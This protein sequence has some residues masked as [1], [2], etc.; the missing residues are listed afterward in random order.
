MKKSER[1]QILKV[2]KS[3]DWDELADIIIQSEIELDILFEELSIKE[4]E[5]YEEMIE[6]YENEKISRISPNAYRDYYELYDF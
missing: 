4:I 3:M 6:I 2:A 5:Y 1:K